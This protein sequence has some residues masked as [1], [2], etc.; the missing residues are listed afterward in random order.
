LIPVPDIPSILQAVQSGT[1]DVGVVPFE[2]STNGSVV[3]SQDL[4]ANVKVYPNVQ[5]SGETFVRV[6]H[7][8]L[9]RRKQSSSTAAAEEIVSQHQ[10]S[11]GQESEKEYEHIRQLFSHKQAWTQC[12][13]FLS[14]YLPG[15]ERTDTTSTSEAAKKVAEDMTG[16]SA[17]ISSEAAAKLYGL[18]ILAK[19]IEEMAENT[20]RFLVIR[21][22]DST[23][24]P[25]RPTESKSQKHKSLLTFTIPHDSP[26]ALASALAVFGNHGIN[27]TSMNSR[28]SGER[29][30]HYIF[31]V[32]FGGKRGDENIE[33]AL[34]QLGGVVEG[35]RLIGSWV[36]GDA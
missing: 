6:R 30:W 22:S 16:S 27:L 34:E 35:W 3:Q 28:P 14:T 32:E 29:S 26:G 9:G 1:T 15:R 8:L 4:L 23:P 36:S 12:T 31:F 21:S 10:G 17:A 7:C 25:P 18:D 33:Q 11:G 13:P 19:N 5:V 2:N 20:T 24:P